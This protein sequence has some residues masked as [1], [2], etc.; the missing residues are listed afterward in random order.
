MPGV[1]GANVVQLKDPLREELSEEKIPDTNPAE[2]FS[3]CD[4]CTQAT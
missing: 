4:G 3:D 1:D 2:L